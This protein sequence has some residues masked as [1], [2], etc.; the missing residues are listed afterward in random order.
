MPSIRQ[1][2]GPDGTLVWLV[3]SALPC[4]GRTHEVFRG[5]GGVVSLPYRG[6][7]LSLSYENHSNSQNPSVLRCPALA[8]TPSV[9]TKISRIPPGT[10]PLSE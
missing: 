10:R 1:V 5:L 6:R 4:S 7:N 9:F 2:A 3:R 8:E